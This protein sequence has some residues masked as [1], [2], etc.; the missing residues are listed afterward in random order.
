MKSA[1]SKIAVTSRTLAMYHR[2]MTN[3]LTLTDS[4]L[5]SLP[6]TDATTFVIPALIP[7]GATPLIC[8]CA[9]DDSLAGTP[10]IVTDAPAKLHPASV[11]ACPAVSQL[12][13]SLFD[14]PL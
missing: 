14:T 8:V 12:L 5:L 7:S 4:V 10:L 13:P 11:N 1:P 9:V 2:P 3:Y 6:L